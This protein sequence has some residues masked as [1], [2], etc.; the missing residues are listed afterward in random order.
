MYLTALS[1]LMRDPKDAR[2]I[3]SKKIRTAFDRAMTPAEAEAFRIERLNAA[4]R[5]KRAGLR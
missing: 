3:T 2:P 1:K 5:G 4:R